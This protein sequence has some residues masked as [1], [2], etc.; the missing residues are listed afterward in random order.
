MKTHLC[1]IFTCNSKSGALS[2]VRP[3]IGQPNAL[4]VVAV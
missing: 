2:N 3:Q 4:S 1:S